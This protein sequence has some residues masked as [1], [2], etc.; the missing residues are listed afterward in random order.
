MLPV[1]R[2][3]SVDQPKDIRTNLIVWAVLVVVVGVVFF[4]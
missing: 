2:D 4:A 1:D 3:E